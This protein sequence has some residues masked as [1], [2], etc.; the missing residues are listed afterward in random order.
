M[1]K[2]YTKAFYREE[3]NIDEWLNSFIDKD[4]PFVES[5][6]EVIGYASFR[7]GII[8]TIKKFEKILLQIDETSKS[9]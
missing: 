8:I 6:Y 3:D 5:N 9:K 4:K 7:D 1:Y 2:Y